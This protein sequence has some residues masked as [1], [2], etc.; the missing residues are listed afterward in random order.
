MNMIKTELE[1]YEREAYEQFFNAMIS[2]PNDEKELVNAL[3]KFVPGSDT[4]DFLYLIM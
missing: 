4:H 3:K 2:T 1:A